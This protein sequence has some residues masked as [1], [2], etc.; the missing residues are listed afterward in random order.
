[1]VCVWEISASPVSTILLCVS[2]TYSLTNLQ[3]KTM[4]TQGWLHKHTEGSGR[5]TEA[6]TDAWENKAL[7]S[8]KSFPLLSLHV[9]NVA[10]SLP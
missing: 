5:Q 7:K 9:I 2:L 3:V 8:S 10:S 1:M 6:L 4:T